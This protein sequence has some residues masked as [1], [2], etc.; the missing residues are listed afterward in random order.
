MVVG[1]LY[2]GPGPGPGPREDP[3]SESG[4]EPGPELEQGADLEVPGWG[5]RSGSGLGLVVLGLWQGEE[6]IPRLA[7]GRLHFG[8]LL[9]L[10]WF[11]ARF[12]PGL[13]MV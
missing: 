5:S 11:L 13:A 4:P 6:P 10:S 8:G 3:E 12:V 1:L 9:E 2:F 7:S